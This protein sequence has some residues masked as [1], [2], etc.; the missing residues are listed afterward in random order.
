MKNIK[1]IS[2]PNTTEGCNRSCFIVGISCDE[3]RQITKNGEMAGI[4]WFQIIKD[5]KVIAEIKESVCDIFGEDEL[6]K[7]S[8]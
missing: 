3:I 7:V 2:F 8:F 4:A 6:P 1:E 5:G